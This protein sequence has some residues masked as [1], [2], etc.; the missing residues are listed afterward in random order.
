MRKLPFALAALT[1]LSVAA[2]G[3]LDP[4]AGE[5]TPLATVTGQLTNP[6]AVQTTSNVR[7]AVIW[8]AELFGK[9][10]SAVDLPVQPVFPS[11]FKIDLREAPPE[12]VLWDPF[13]KSQSPS[14]PPQTGGST[15]AQPA[16]PAAPG[17]RGAHVGLQGGTA[18]GPSVRVAVGAVVAYEDLNGNGKLDLVD[19]NA[20]Q[21]LDRIVAANDQTMLIY[22]DGT[23]PN[24]PE[25]RDGN[26]HYPTPGYNLYRQGANC[27]TTDIGGAPG[28]GE[29]LGGTKGGT[30]APACTPVAPE[31]LPMTTL[32]DLALA[33]DPKFGQLMCR[34]GGDSVSSASAGGAVH[35][36]RP[37]TYPAPTDPNLSCNADG[38]GY[39]Y[40]K[41]TCTTISQGPCRGTITTCTPVDFWERPTPVP[42]DWP[43]AAK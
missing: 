35:P 25:L 26:G 24:D 36:G 28:D 21:F 27:A 17:T 9:F 18:V 32:Y 23:P 34:N 14:D 31:W 6:Q 40:G 4:N 39:T 29:P 41:S 42:A 7:I 8:R 11:K 3:S 1:S 22:F 16:D 5:K 43:C 33:T 13:A 20:A 38:G 2:C 37:A 30:P 15:P 10:N 12:G 19:D